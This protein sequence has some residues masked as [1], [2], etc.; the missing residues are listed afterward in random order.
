M[1]RGW[2]PITIAT[3]IGL[4]ASFAIASN[5]HRWPRECRLVASSAGDFTI[6][7]W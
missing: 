4:P 6:A 3:A 7:R 5:R 2:Q 1:I